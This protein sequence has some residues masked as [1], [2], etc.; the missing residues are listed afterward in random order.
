MAEFPV[1]GFL[2]FQGIFDLSLLNQLLL[3]HSF[4]EYIFSYSSVRL[5]STINK[6]LTDSHTRSM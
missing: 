2:D 1:G 6:V 4:I 5:V 3:N